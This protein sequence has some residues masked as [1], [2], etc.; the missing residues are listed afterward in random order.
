MSTSI[1]LP[2]ERYLGIDLHKHYLVIGGVNAKQ[3]VVLPPRRIELGDWPTW[4]KTH[5]T[6]SDIVVVEATTN[7]WDFYDQTAP[8]VQRV[9]VANAA[10][11]ALIAKT[12]TKTDNKDVMCPARLS[13]ARL[14]PEVWVPPME[15]R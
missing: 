1:S 5:L 7:A 3:E 10:K 11:I 2:I 14:I 6:K 12:R 15:L 9:I 13:S 4:A 8:L